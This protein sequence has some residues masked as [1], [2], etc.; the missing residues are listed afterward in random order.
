MLAPRFAPFRDGPTPFGR[1]MDDDAVGVFAGF[2]LEAEGCK[3]CAYRIGARRFVSEHHRPGSSYECDAHDAGP[4]AACGVG[5]AGRYNH[6]RRLP[7]VALFVVDEP[8]FVVL[9]EAGSFALVSTSTPSSQPAMVSGP[10]SKADR[11]RL[12]SRSCSSS[13]RPRPSSCGPIVPRGAPGE[14]DVINATT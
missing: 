1:K 4:S 8:C 13:I 12:R 9:L 14:H 5:E 10:S 7:M 3:P 6:A 2:D 11:R